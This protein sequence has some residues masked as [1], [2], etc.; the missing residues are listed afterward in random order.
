MNVNCVI[1]IHCFVLT[2]TCLP[3]IHMHTIFGLGWG[4]WFVSGKSLVAS[5][6]VTILCSEFNNWFH[7]VFS[8]E[9][10]SLKYR[11]G[12]FQ[13]TVYADKSK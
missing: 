7:S 10:Y 4:F 1:Y 11:V 8:R 6:F 9:N 3:K 12:L 2:L 5:Q 13:I